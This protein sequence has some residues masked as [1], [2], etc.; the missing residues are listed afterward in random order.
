M[1]VRVW[2]L[3]TP[4]RKGSP[5]WEQFQ[6]KLRDGSQPVQV[7]V[8]S[9]PGLAA[10]GGV[11][12]VYREGV[13]LREGEV[14]PTKH[15]ARAVTLAGE[16]VGSPLLHYPPRGGSLP[17]GA[18][19]PRLFCTGAGPCKLFRLDLL[20]PCGFRRCAGAGLPARAADGGGS[21]KV[22]DERFFIP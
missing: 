17:L 4:P 7:G 15:G 3:A 22:G 20:F 16:G 21:D 1:C 18:G 6:S 14:T 9:L 8:P 10:A 2:G 5:L 19:L 13:G 11:A 12:D